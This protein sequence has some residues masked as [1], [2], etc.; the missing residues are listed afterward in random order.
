MKTFT[1][2]Q[3]QFLS[4]NVNAFYHDE[5]RR[6]NWNVRGSV[7]NLI[8]SFKNDISVTPNAIMAENKRT[9]MYILREDLLEIQNAIAP[10][11]L[12]VCVIP[13]AKK[14]SEYFSYQKQFREVVKQTVDSLNGFVD[15]TNYIQ[16]IVNTRTT[17]RDKAGF[18]GD[19]ELPY[20]GITLHTCSISADVENKD[21]LLIDDL[22]TKSI[23]IDEDALEALLKKGAKSVRFYAV[24]RTVF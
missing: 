5:Y 20:P 23:N 14:D 10:N 11:T 22:Y 24:G 3:N 12:T 7:E 4:R 9:L 2:L 8:C 15:G 16:R 13:R 17:H 19:G 21:I 6:G 1:I 18:G